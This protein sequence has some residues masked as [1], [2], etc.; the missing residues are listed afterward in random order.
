[1]SK[2]K[3]VFILPKSRACCGD[4]IMKKRRLGQ[5]WSIDIIIAVIIFVLII[6]VFYAILSSR[7]ESTVTDLRAESQTVSAKLRDESVNS[8]TGIMVDG[9]IQE[10]KLKELCQLSY[11][12]VKRKLGIE[13]EFCIYIEDQEGNIVPIPCGGTEKAG[14]GSDNIN[15]SPDY[16]CNSNYS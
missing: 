12:E 4:L 14:I 10:D 1:M 6:S 7:S 2:K 13:D 3:K 11:E 5:T 16:Y 15:I 8:A 9:V